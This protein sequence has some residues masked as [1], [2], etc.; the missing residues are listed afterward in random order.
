MDQEIHEKLISWATNILT[1]QE[2]NSTHRAELVHMFSREFNTV[3]LFPRPAMEVLIHAFEKDLDR[4]DVSKSPI[5]TMAESISVC[6]RE[7]KLLLAF[8]EVRSEI[9]TRA[10]I[11][12]E[13][14]IKDKFKNVK[15]KRSGKTNT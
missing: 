10:G 6:R 1:T 7:A 11:N 2:R 9:F 12:E 5:P 8:L 4:I 14:H 13:Q 3:L 15:P